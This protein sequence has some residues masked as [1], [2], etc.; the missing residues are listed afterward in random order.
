VKPV[1]L[2]IIAL[3]LGGCAI[4]NESSEV[5]STASNLRTPSGSNAAAAASPAPPAGGLLQGLNRFAQA[6]GAAAKGDNR[7]TS[8]ST[9]TGSAAPGLTV[10]RPATRSSAPPAAATG[11]RVASVEGETPGARPAET[12]RGTAASATVAYEKAMLQGDTRSMARA[13]ARLTKKPITA[14]SIRELNAKLG[15]EADDNMVSEVVRA[16]P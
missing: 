12:T 3:F 4:S 16:A 13:A 15:I 11:R 2:A 7:S 1:R 14:D 8:L 10:T 9:E 5:Q 6:L